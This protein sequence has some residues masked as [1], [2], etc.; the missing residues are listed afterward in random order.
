MVDK[1]QRRATKLIPGLSDLSYEER[2]KNCG[3]T[4]LETR[5]LSGDKIKLFKILNG[6]EI[7]ILIFFKI[8]ER[9]VTRGH[10]CR[11]VN[12]QSTLDVTQYSLSQNATSV[13][14]VQEQNRQVSR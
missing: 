8:K 1:V 13:N 2:L 6:Y 14:Y 7:V 9:K 10:N 11:L 5:R 4:T 3:L 12:K